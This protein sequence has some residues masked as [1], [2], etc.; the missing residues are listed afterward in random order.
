MELTLHRTFL[1]TKATHGA[2][3]IDGV[4]ECLTLEDVVRDLKQDGSGKVQDETA[5]P[6]GRYEVIINFSPRFKK[7]YMRLIDVPFFSGILIHSG[8]TVADTK[9]CIL[10]GQQKDSDT[11]IHGGSVALPLLQAKVQAALDQQEGVWI[12]ILNEF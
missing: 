10:V 7:Q 3:Y 11:H 9:G 2:L 12:T 4:Y 1:G 5:I 6:A 8:N